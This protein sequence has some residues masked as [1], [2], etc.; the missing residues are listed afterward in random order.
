MAERKAARVLPEPV[1]AAISV[2]RPSRMGGQPSRCGGVGSPSR[3]SNHFWTAGWKG[4]REV[5][6]RILTGAGSLLFPLRQERSVGVNIGSVGSRLGVGGERRDV[7]LSL[8]LLLKVVLGRLHQARIL[9][10][11]HGGGGENLRGDHHRLVADRMRGADGL[12]PGMAGGAER[13]RRD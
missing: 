13:E 3:V 10:E 1:G 2:W 5:T 4:A 11:I 6:G 12:G 7:K 9:Q 8:R